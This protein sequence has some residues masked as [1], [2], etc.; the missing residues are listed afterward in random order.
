[1]TREEKQTK[2][3][4]LTYKILSATGFLLDAFGE[5]EQLGLK[6]P[7]F[8]MALKQTAN[9]FKDQLGKAEAVVT[10]HLDSDHIEAADQMGSS[11]ILMDRLLSVH[12]EAGRKLSEEGVIILSKKIENTLT[13][14]GLTL[15]A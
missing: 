14:F 6:S 5:M 9:R 12:L 8:K 13:E 2:A 11:Y 15:P 1:M 10:G 4:D 3:T 7:I